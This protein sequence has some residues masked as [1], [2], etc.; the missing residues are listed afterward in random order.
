MESR[1]RP[2]TSEIL[3]IIGLLGLVVWRRTNIQFDL[4]WLALPL[5]VILI[6]SLSIVWRHKLK[7]KPAEWNLMDGRSFEDQVMLWLRH[8]GYAQIRKTEYYDQGVDIIAAKPGVIL[9][10]QVKRSNSKVGVGAVRAAVAGLRSYGCT[11]AMVVTNSVFTPAAIQ[12]ANANDCL[13]VD[14]EG[15]LSQLRV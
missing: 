8:C 1:N 4:Y 7:L 2:L 12:L 15:L 3:L 14:G 9:G 6:I 13:L 10:V 11:Q 5:L